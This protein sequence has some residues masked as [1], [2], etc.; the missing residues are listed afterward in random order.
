MFRLSDKD[1]GKGKGKGKGESANLAHQFLGL[2]CSGHFVATR[3]YW[4]DTQTSL[5]GDW[6]WGLSSKDGKNQF[7][8]KFGCFPCIFIVPFARA[9]SISKHGKLSRAPN[10]VLKCG[11]IV[12]K[13]PILFQFSMLH[14]IF[15]H[16]FFGERGVK[17][18]LIFLQK[19]YT[20]EVVRWGRC[21]GGLEE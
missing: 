3:Q 2:F 1:K 6:I 11:W 20:N 9:T 14:C 17:F 15:E 4:S 8:L 18:N 7:L 13:S 5:S 12:F 19:S 21:L 16:E 10:K